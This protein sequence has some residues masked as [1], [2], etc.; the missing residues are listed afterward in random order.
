MTTTTLPTP[1]HSLLEL[2]RL[3]GEFHEN[4]EQSNSL[5]QPATREEIV[6]ALDECVSSIK[7]LVEE[8]A[9]QLVALQADDDENDTGLNDLG[10]FASAF[11][12][13][14]SWLEEMDE[15]AAALSE[16]EA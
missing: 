1:T 14:Q 12:T 15:D 11:G 2:K 9:A 10:I 3:M 8:H 7:S 13:L 4:G 5:A 16:V 6:A